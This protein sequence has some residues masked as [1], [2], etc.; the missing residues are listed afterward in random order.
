MAFFLYGSG[1]LLDIGYTRLRKD[2]VDAALRSVLD[3][4]LRSNT[5]GLT[6]MY[7]LTYNLCTYLY[8]LSYI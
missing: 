5:L 4:L 2:E 3:N 1:R 6:Y 7:Y 8:V